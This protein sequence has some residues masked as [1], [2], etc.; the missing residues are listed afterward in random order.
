MVQTK[1]NSTK[2][3]KANELLLL[4]LLSLL[5]PRDVLEVFSIAMQYSFALS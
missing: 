3:P 5:L 2:I 1:I 4:L